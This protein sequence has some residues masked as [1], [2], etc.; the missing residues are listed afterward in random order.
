M[1]C[2]A[3]TFKFKAMCIKKYISMMGRVLHS[4]PPPPV[5]GG[6]GNPPPLEK[7]M[8]PLGKTR[9]GGHWPPLGN[10]WKSVSVRP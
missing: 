2:R 9:G 3:K 10:P 6:G 4:P 1:Y 8:P 7:C 5:R